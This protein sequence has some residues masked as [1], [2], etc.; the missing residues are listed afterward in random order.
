MILLEQYIELRI[1]HF[2]RLAKYDVV[3]AL[4]DNGSISFKV[5]R[6]GDYIFTL[7]LQNTQDLSFELSELDRELNFTIDWELYSKV[8]AAL[9]SVFLNEVPS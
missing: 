9:F 1:F 5:L 4:R 7:V 6:D 3:Q 8:E 2:K